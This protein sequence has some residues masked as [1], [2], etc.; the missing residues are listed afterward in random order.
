M[1]GQ[2][3]SRWLGRV[4]HETTSIIEYQQQS[5]EPQFKSVPE[6]TTV[7]FSVYVSSLRR[8]NIARL[9]STIPLHKGSFATAEHHRYFL[10]TTNYVCD[11]FPEVSPS[12]TQCC[13]PQRTAQWLIQ[14][15]QR[16]SWP[17]FWY[18]STH[19]P[20]HYSESKEAQSSIHIER[21]MRS[22]CKRDHTF[23][24]NANL[25]IV[26]IRHSGRSSNRYY[27]KEW[28]VPTVI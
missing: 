10:S 19:Q 11:I 23:L 24:S 21:L 13:F 14:A 7:H 25:I 2:S 15:S 8:I 22:W 17:S 12:L 16:Q 4:S 18:Q 6:C 28:K 26:S 3:Y 27:C 1:G 20:K 9:N 5:Y